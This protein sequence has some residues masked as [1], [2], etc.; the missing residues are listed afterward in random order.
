[1]LA[2]ATA[3]IALSAGM[4]AQ[5]VPYQPTL[6]INPS[7]NAIC[8]PTSSA[9]LASPIPF[10]QGVDDVR[11]PGFGGKEWIQFSQVGGDLP[12]DTRSAFTPGQNEYGAPES[13][14]SVVYVRLS[15]GFIAA[16]SPWQRI[17]PAEMPMDSLDAATRDW[18]REYGMTNQYIWAEL[19]AGRQ[20]WLRERGYTYS[21]RTFTG[22]GYPEVQD[23]A[24]AGAIKPVTVIERPDDQPRFKQKMQVRS[25]QPSAHDRELAAIAKEI[26]RGNARI[27]M[28][29]IGDKQAL[30]Q[31]VAR[32]KS[33][34]VRT[35]DAKPE[36]STQERRDE[37][38]KKV[39]TR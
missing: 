26:S 31:A 18:I 35:A 15:S 17:D 32:A 36:T 10:N 4:G 27:S 16:I 1:M 2:A 34:E 28:P 20:A 14:D 37:Q 3:A 23:Q 11:R 7:P 38:A 13:D 30:A 25:P 21:V 6:D 39:A 29:P 8:P 12:L 33:G 22:S 19:E 24:G 9:F 5:P